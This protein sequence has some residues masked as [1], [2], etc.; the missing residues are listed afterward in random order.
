MQSIVS[1]QGDVQPLGTGML[2]KGLWSSI[3]PV[4]PGLGLPASARE[5]GRAGRPRLFNL[6]QP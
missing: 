4:H 2:A 6:E 1:P 5:Q 3:L